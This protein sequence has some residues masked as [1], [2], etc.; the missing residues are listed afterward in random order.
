VFILCASRPRLG[1]MVE[2]T[3]LTGFACA[4][5]V[6]ATKRVRLVVGVTRIARGGL[7]VRRLQRRYFGVTW[8][9]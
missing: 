8:S 6:L 3:V 9:A 5:E 7:R 2:A 1:I 4:P